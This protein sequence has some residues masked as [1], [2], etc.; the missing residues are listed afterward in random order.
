M[1]KFDRYFKNNL[2]IFPISGPVNGGTSINVSAN[3]EGNSTDEIFLSIDEAECT[4]VTVRDQ[5][6]W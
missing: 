1:M 3:Y 4:G 6:N 2:Q 5:A